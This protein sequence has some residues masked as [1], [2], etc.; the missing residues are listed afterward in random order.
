MMRRGHFVGLH[1]MTAWYTLEWKEKDGTTVIY[2]N[3]LDD[4]KDAGSTSPSWSCGVTYGY[5]L[6]IDRTGNLGL[7]FYVGLGYQ[8]YQY[9][10]IIPSDGW[11]YYKHYSKHKVGLTKIGANLTY[12]FSL[13]RVRR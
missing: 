6:P 9:K 8:S 10:R 13:R 7:E 5:S 3:G 1:G 12:R 2:Q 4:V 11:N